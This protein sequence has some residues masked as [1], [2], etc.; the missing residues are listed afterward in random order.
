MSYQNYTSSTY[1]APST[2]TDNSLDS[3]SPSPTNAVSSDSV[4]ICVDKKKNH[5]IQSSQNDPLLASPSHILS[6]GQSSL[7]LHYS[8]R[9]GCCNAPFWLWPYLV[10]PVIFL[11][12]FAVVLLLGVI[13]VLQFQAFGSNA[14]LINGLTTGSIAVISLF[15]GPIIG[16][17]S[18]NIGR[19]SIML[20][21]CLLSLVSI[22]TLTFW[23]NM[24][25]Y[26]IAVAVCGAF[27]GGVDNMNVYLLYIADVVPVGNRT[28]FIAWV[29]AALAIALIIA[30]TLG[31]TLFTHFGREVVGIV[32]GSVALCAAIFIVVVLPEPLLAVNKI[33]GNKETTIGKQN[34]R[35]RLEGNFNSLDSIR[36]VLITPGPLRIIVILSFMDNLL[37]WGFIGTLAIYLTS[38]PLLLYTSTEFS[39]LV[40]LYG[41]LMVVAHIFV[42]PTITP[43]LGERTVIQIGLF[44]QGLQMV[45]FGFAKSHAMVTM[46]TC[47]VLGSTLYAPP[48]SSLVAA[49]IPDEQRGK[50]QTAFNSLTSLC[51]GMAPM[52]FGIFLKLSS[53]F[54]YAGLPYAVGGMCAWGCVVITIYLPRDTKEMQRLTKNDYQIISDNNT[55]EGNVASIA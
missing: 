32:S 30:P 24:V 23:D 29:F 5:H 20:Y 9:R 47:L 21:G 15:T 43:C 55:A 39:T 25:L 26:Q 52:V 10:Y 13:P 50:L 4:D 2:P 7:K 16:G 33:N 51:V 40:S 41:I 11:E 48:A 22:S 12:T 3:L 34:I 53:N 14:I 54:E 36:H 28:T 35:N 38:N 17:V 19:K 44:L 49:A 8:L 31:A 1:G 45:S 27:R 42:V 37:K 46:S 6:D 18:D